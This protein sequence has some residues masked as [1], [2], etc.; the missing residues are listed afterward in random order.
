MLKVLKPV[1]TSGTFLLILTTVSNAAFAA[2]TP[3]NG[4]WR[5]DSLKISVSTGDSTYD[6]IYTDAL[7]QWDRL[8]NLSISST[9]K[10]GKFYAGTVYKTG[11]SYDGICYTRKNSRGYIVSAEVF[12][13]T[14]FTDSYPSGRKLGVATHEIGHGLGLKHNNTVTQQFSVMVPETVVDRQERTSS[15]QSVDTKP[16]N[17]RYKLLYNVPQE[18]LGDELDV[19]T[20]IDYS[21]ANTYDDLTELSEEADL[22]VKAKVVKNK[23][24]LTNEEDRK[25]VLTSTTFKVK[26]VLKGNKALKNEEIMVNQ[27][28]GEVNG[29]RVY[30]DEVTEFTAKQEI[31]L[32]LKE[33]ESG[34]YYTINGDQGVLFENKKNSEEYSHVSF[35]FFD[36]EDIEKSIKVD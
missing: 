6:Q 10:L 31:Y 8:S 21:W 4:S 3:I 1:I 19:E 13:N 30:S 11:A 28:I 12:L 14:S 24:K 27:D 17:A 36:E 2:D 26:D 15:P 18:Y 20:E 32:Y 23:S 16:L 9:S 25:Y 5:S 22:V 35:G 34:N 33:G 7:N 29:Y